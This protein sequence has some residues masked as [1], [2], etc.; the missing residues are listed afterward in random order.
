MI[1][2][3]WLWWEFG[4]VSGGCGVCD[5]VHFYVV[6]NWFMVGGSNNSGRLEF[7]VLKD[8]NSFTDTRVSFF[9]YVCFTYLYGVKNKVQAGLIL[10]N[11]WFVSLTIYV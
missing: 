3:W 7:T 10:R 9:C 5:G 1:R 11:L 6:G 4:K 2:E 8:N